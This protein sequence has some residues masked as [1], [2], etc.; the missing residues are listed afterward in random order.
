M[1]KIFEKL[2]LAGLGAFSLS[3]EKVEEFVDELVKRGEVTQDEKAKIITDT[4]KKVEERT[5]Q[6]K[7]WVEESVAATME[8]MK[9]KMLNDIEQLKVKVEKLEKSNKKMQKEL[10]ELK[11]V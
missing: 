1:E 7:A 9:P 4:M 5:K 3:K 10:K 11:Q 2:Y 6:A 8:K